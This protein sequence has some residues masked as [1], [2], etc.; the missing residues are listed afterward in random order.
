MSRADKRRPP[1]TTYI[2]HIPLAT[3]LPRIRHLINLN[4]LRGPFP[5]GTEEEDLTRLVLALKDAKTPATDPALS[6]Q[7]LSPTS[8]GELKSDG[9]QPPE[10][11][12]EGSRDTT[13]QS[14]WAGLGRLL[15]WRP[16]SCAQICEASKGLR[17]IPTNTIFF[18]WLLVALAG[19]AIATCMLDVS[20]ST[21]FYK[22]SAQTLSGVDTATFNAKPTAIRTSATTCHHR[23]ATSSLATA[24]DA[25]DVVVIPNRST[26]L[27]LYYR[28]G[29][30][31]LSSR[32]FKAPVMP[33][34]SSSRQAPEKST[35]KASLVTPRSLHEI[36]TETAT[37]PLAQWAAAGYSLVG[38]SG[39]LLLRGA[40]E[41]WEYWK[42]QLLSLWLEVIQPMIL[43]VQEG[44]TGFFTNLHEECRGG[45]AAASAYAHFYGQRASKQA[46]AL[47]TDPAALGRHI[48]AT[49]RGYLKYQ[50]KASTTASRH[51]IAASQQAAIYQRVAATQ[52]KSLWT[53]LAASSQR[54]TE[55]ARDPSGLGGASSKG[56]RSLRSRKEWEGVF[57]KLFPE[58]QAK[59]KAGTAKVA[60]EPRRSPLQRAKT[61]ARGAFKGLKKSQKSGPKASKRPAGKKSKKVRDR[62]AGSRSA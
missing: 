12:S 19:M 15:A 54:F 55:V 18:R 56:D 34:L 31:N 58:T 7:A 52:L 20:R 40:S 24:C 59:A 21:S 46:H 8:P 11:S 28:S 41:E 47:T 26:D 62:K 60:G 61:S 30:R 39:R 53:S 16:T 22:T 6:S 29:L 23:A 33:T 50:T 25:C 49:Y 37:D 38:E 27:S 17:S 2:W 3:N 48:E 42:Q 57:S 1:L 35:P 45:A 14:I 13:G 5:E 4:E 44:V 9:A 36:V 43:Q 51:F 10:P 32:A